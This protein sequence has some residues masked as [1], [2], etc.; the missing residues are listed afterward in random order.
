MISAKQSL[1]QEVYGKLKELIIY[2]KIQPGDIITVGEMAE[3]FNVSKTPVRDS[4]NALK[5]E[6]LIEVLPYKGYFVSRV[7][8][9]ILLDLFQMRTILEGAAAELAAKNATAEIIE[10]LT[11]LAYKDLTGQEN[12]VSFM[13]T[14]FNFHM[15]IA[16]A[17]GNQY[18]CKSLSNV[19]EQL[20]RVLYTDLISGDPEQ[21]QKEHQEL[22]QCIINQDHNEAKRLVNTQIEATRKRILKNI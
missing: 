21:M 18:L 14:N 19:L 5:H 16:A 3:R 12:T 11:A 22:V 2:N 17:S 7:D 10:G 4:L 1:A 6:G 15:A 20:Q 9:K 8:I 13:Q